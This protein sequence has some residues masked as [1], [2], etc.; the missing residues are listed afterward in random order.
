MPRDFH[1]ILT[2]SGGVRGTFAGFPRGHV[3]IHA[4]LRRMVRVTRSKQASVAADERVTF[5]K[6]GRYRNGLRS[7]WSRPL[8]RCGDGVSGV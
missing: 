3:V 8:G 5:L 4:A 1:L 6:S 2:L 7:F